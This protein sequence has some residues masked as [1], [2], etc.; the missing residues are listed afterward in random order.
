[1]GKIKFREE[2]FTWTNNRNGE[3]FIQER[4]DRVFGSVDWTLKYDKAEVK[5]ILRQSSD[6]SMILL[7]SDPIRN[8]T[9]SRF[10]FQNR[11]TR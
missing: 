7:D 9:R 1:M 8:K 10:I 11:W 2:S 3:G 6:H 5:H 4:L